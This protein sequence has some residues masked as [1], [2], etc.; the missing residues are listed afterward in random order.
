MNCT[1]IESGI[2]RTKNLLK[3]D[4]NEVITHNF[5]GS[6]S[7]LFQ[8]EWINKNRKK[9]SCRYSDEIK[10]FAVTLHFYSPKV[11][12]YC[13]YIFQIVIVIYKNLK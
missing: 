4:P 11:Y 2:I 9:R 6:V 10:K 8:N 13:R 7:E 3:R 5:D 12:N 1:N